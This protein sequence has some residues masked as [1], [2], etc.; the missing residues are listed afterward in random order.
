MEISVDIPILGYRNIS[1]SL[2]EEGYLVTN[3]LDTGK[4]FFIGKEK[5]QEFVNY[6][7]ANYEGYRI[8]YVDSNGN[9]SDDEIIQHENEIVEDPIV[10]MENDLAKN[11]IIQNIN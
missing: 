5:V 9:S 8:V 11:V 3:I 7:I 1:C 10:T 2:T 6:I 4:A